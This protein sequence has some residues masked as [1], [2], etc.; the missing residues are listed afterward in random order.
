MDQDRLPVMHQPVDHGSRESIIDVE[1]LAPLFEDSVR[2]DNDR[3]SLI[4]GCHDLEH[5]VRTAFVNR[6]IPQL[7]EKKKLWAYVLI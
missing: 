5:Q 1:D 3:S 4:S 2:R 6:K 7:I